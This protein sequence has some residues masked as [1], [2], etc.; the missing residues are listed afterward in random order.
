MK[1]MRSALLLLAVL[2][3]ISAAAQAPVPL[4]SPQG[5][6]FDQQGRLFVADYDS[7][8]VVVYNSQLVQSSVISAG[9]SGPD[10]LA[11][12]TLGNLYVCNAKG[13]SITVYGPDGIQKTDKTIT[14][15]VSSPEEVAVDAYA[16][17]FVANNGSANKITVYNI[18]GQLIETLTQD[19]NGRNFTAPGVVVV[20]GMNVYVGTGPTSGQSYVSEY[21]VGEFLTGSLK[22]ISSY[23]DTADEGP[24][25]IAF[26]Q[27]G[28]L[29]VSDFYTATVVK[30]SQSGQILLTISTGSC[31]Q[32]QGVA[33]DVQGNIYASYG[34]SISVYSSSGQLR[35]TLH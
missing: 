3:H 11:I 25:G 10:R 30:Y 31:C 2:T 35:K 14:N 15:Q 7:D 19:H 12:D 29:Y 21:N 6:V 1:P 23:F 13:N 9:M 28:N 5:M 33:V 22:R 17:V 32:N 8:H 18:D 24:T 4:A 26:D 16:D 27:A 34:N 20:Q